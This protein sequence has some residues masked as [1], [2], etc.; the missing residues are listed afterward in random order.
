MVSNAPTAHQLNFFGESFLMIRE[1]ALQKWK[2]ADVSVVR[3]EVRSWLDVS[4]SSRIQRPEHLAI[5][6]LNLLFPDLNLL[7][8]EF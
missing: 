1:K 3:H 8:P 7:F 2:S 4:I 5:T 6:D